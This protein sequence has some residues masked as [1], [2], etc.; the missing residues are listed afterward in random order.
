M[1]TLYIRDVSDEV[2]ATLKVRAAEAGTS[3]SA[4][5]SR[6]LE[7]LAARPTNA[8]IVEQLRSRDRSEG[9]TTEEILAA[10]EAGRR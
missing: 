7:R 2:A 10:V 8:Q 1:A 9:P 4:Y 5:V 3:L 6:E